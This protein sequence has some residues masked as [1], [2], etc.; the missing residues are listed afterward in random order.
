MKKTRY[1]AL[2]D[3]L[4]NKRQKEIHQ[5]LQ[6]TNKENRKVSIRV[7]SFQLV[8]SEVIIA[9]TAIDDFLN[10]ILIE[11]YFRDITDVLKSKRYIQFEKYVLSRMGLNDKFLWVS[12]LVNKYLPL[13]TL[14]SE[15]TVL[16]NQFAHSFTD[17]TYYKKTFTYKGKSI[18]S[19]KQFELFNNDI[20]TIVG[21]LAY[22]TKLYK[23]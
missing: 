5:V 14:I 2:L 6:I 17:A 19:V 18:F 3:Y 15:I 9:Y 13:R 10:D 8:Q 12:S 4:N 1:E 21:L 23:D 20:E 11:L 16:R 7:A 22:D